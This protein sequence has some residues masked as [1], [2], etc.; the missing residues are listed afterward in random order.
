M[1]IYASPLMATLVKTSLQS[2][3][4]E[5]IIRVSRSEAFHK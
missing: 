3:P 2:P 1:H 4:V 5:H